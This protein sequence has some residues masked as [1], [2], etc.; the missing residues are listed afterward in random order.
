MNEWAGVFL[1]I[2]ALAAVVQCVFVVIAA[3]SLRRSG[4]RVQEIAEKFDTEMRPTLQDL[5]QGA[6]NLRSISDSARDQATKLEALL[7]TTL[8]SVETTIESARTLV[9]RPLES[10]GD[11]SALWGGFR[12]GFSA[13]RESE[14]RRRSAP[15]AARRPDDSDEHMFIG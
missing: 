3:R 13:Y 15:P 12:R 7:A 8:D 9:L 6:A 11:L 4:A 2:M 1:G 14:S 5:R 10:L